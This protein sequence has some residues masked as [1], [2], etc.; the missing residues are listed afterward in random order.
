MFQQVQYIRNN[1]KHAITQE[2]KAHRSNSR[3]QISS[4]RSYS[5]LLTHC[6]MTFKSLI[7]R[8]AWLKTQQPFL[9]LNYKMCMSKYKVYTPRTWR[10]WSACSSL[11]SPKKASR[12]RLWTCKNRRGEEDQRISMQSVIV[13]TSNLPEPILSQ[14]HQSSTRSH[15]H[16]CN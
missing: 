9:K 14:L 1:H 13:L 4:L 3:T 10:L 7:Q 12:N 11:A 8:S 5:I 15:T 2:I 16:H 6:I